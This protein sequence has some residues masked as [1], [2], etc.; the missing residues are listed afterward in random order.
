MAD[1]SDVASKLTA[2]SK[3]SQFERQKAEAEAKRAKEKAETAAVLREFEASFDDGEDRHVLRNAPRAAPPP[4][5]RHFTSSGLKSGPGSL[6]PAYTKKR[7]FDDYAERRGRGGGFA[8]HDNRR[9]SRDDEGDEEDKAAA[10]P[11]LH[12]SSMPPGTSPAVV[13]GLFAHTPLN[14]EN[15][16]ILPAAGANGPVTE[17]KSTSAIVTLATE[18]PA[19]DIDTVVSHL[20]NKY[21]GFG[22]KLSISR[23][24]SSAALSNTTLLSSASSNLPFGARSV[25]Q[26]IS[27]SRAPPP[28]QRFA[29]PQSYTS[30]TPYGRGAQT[31]VTVQSPSDLKQLKLIHKTLEALLT[32]GPEFEALLMSRP[33]IQRDEKWSWLWDSTSVGGV[34]YRWRLWEVLTNASKR[35]KQR[36]PAQEVLFEG[37][38]SWQPPDESLRF[39]YTTQ[40]DEFVSD[41]DYNS[42]DEEDDDDGRG[43]DLAR[44]YNDHNTAGVSNTDD[45]ANDGM[46]YLDPLAKAKLTHLL[47]RLPDSTSK[48][49]R[50]DVVRITAFAIEHAGAGG[51]EVAALITRNVVR[52]FRKL[53]DR[54]DSTSAS[55]VGLYVISDILSS[56]ASAGVRHAWRYRTLFEQAIRRQKVFERLGRAEKDY[57]WGKLKGE[58]WKR[59]VQNLLSL[60][61]GWSVFPQAAQESFTEAFLNPPLTEEEKRI[62]EAAEMESRQKERDDA[63]K[64]KV[65]SRWRNVD[66]EAGSDAQM[67]DF[68]GTPMADDD[69]DDDAAIDLDNIDG[70][71]MVDSSDEEME[72]EATRVDKTTTIVELGQ[73][74]MSESKPVEAPPVAAVTPASAG[75][76]GRRLRPKA[77]DMFADES[78]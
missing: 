8:H 62:A 56:S 73:K 71:S 32:Y 4:G 65:T 55:M 21:L 78:D 42:S 2:P 76:T 33:D 66:D 60:W 67:D 18:T 63:Q 20:Q 30:P 3:K 35:R 23:H 36:G 57:K 29:P 28:N 10:K 13:K 11:T 75:P 44:R 43:G 19:T 69:G 39:E 16:R 5:K 53:E 49:R 48:L 9:T 34:Y 17:R 64:A 7:P 50:G 54:D 61:E 6:G 47:A 14:V 1:F 22:F 74:R 70:V 26:Q 51:D 41:E 31:Q 59:S 25:V 37:Q 52:P 38:S 45:A 12:L 77:A 72:T 68:D 46:G 15:V 40:L 58:K 27:L 24:L